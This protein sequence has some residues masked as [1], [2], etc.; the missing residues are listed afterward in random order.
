MS[1][2]ATL[3]IQSIVITKRWY[4]LELLRID[5]YT[6]LHKSVIFHEVLSHELF[7]FVVASIHFFV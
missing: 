4:S 7:S 3:Y 5:V 1:Y 2:L 6:S